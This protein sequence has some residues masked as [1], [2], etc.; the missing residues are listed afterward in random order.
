[1]NLTEKSVIIGAKE[2]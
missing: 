2:R 1:L